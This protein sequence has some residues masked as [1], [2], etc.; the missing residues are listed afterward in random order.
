MSRLISMLLCVSMLAVFVTSCGG[1]TTEEAPS[2]AA[3]ST[4]SVDPDKPYAGTTLKWLTWSSQ[5]VTSICDRLDEFYEETGITVEYEQ[6]SNDDLASKTAVVMGAGGKD[7]DVF[8]F[9]TFMHTGMYV[10][11][12]WCEPLNSYFEDDPDFD[13]ADYFDVARQLSEVDGTCYAVP[14]NSEQMVLYYNTAMFEKAGLTSPPETWE[15]MVEYAAKLNDPENGVYG[16]TTRGD[17]NA[18]VV[19]WIALLRAYGGD[20]FVDGKATINSEAAIKAIEMYKQL[21]EYCPPGYLSK[22]WSETSDDFAQGIAAMRFDGD[23]QY[24]WAVDDESSLVADD[25][26]FA[27]LPRGDVKASTTTSVWGMA[28]SSGSENK[29]AAWEFIRWCTDKARDAEI[30]MEGH[31]SARSSTWENEAVREKYP[32]SLI[33]AVVESYDITDGSPLP[34]ITY[35]AEGR[36]IIGDVLALAWQGEDY[37][38]ALDEANEEFQELIDYDFK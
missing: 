17:G 32:A 7:V 16:I 24:T 30:A 12:G 28:I 20:Y 37:R 33:E 29:G 11:N 36:S 8:N 22:N 26:E 31:F 25:V 18:S 27:V 10:E 2:S 38:A 35:S 13:Y 9:R 1:D 23:A 21:L 4:D 19:L 34:V 15:Q 5:W 14:V 6:L 3:P